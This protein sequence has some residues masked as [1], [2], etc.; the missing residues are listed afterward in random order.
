MATPTQG[1]PAGFDA[2]AFRNAVKFAMQMGSPTSTPQKVTFQWRVLK[3]Y[4]K[5]D[6]IDRPYDWTSNP[7]STTAHTDVVV[8]CA[9]EFGRVAGN[10]TERNPVGDFDSVRA[11]ITVLDVDYVLIAGADYVSI[12]GDQYVIE[13]VQ[14]MALFDVDVYQIHAVA[15][16]ES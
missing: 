13:Y 2:S 16:D 7:T 8:D 4:A 12:G 5:E 1:I 11:I 3:E 9:V 10:I 6:V 14:P 15:V